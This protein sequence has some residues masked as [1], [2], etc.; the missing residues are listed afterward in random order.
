VTKPRRKSKK[1]AVRKPG[2]AEG[3]RQLRHVS[4]AAVEALH[5]ESLAEHGGL[6]GIRDEGLLESALARCRNRAVYEPDSSLAE[7]AASLAF[8]LAKNHPFND[9]N[10]RIALIASFL[11]VELN[12]YRVS[13]TESEAYAAIYGL[14]AGELS[15][16]D[17]SEWLAAHLKPRRR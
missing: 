9:G 16:A 2:R 10:K 1:K 5:R 15:E 4:R 6:E 7:L 13:A 12:G 17:L 11:F 8:G 14:A 3:S